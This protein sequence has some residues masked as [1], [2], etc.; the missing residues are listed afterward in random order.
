MLGSSLGVF[1]IRGMG[2]YSSLFAVKACSGLACHAAKERIAT[3]FQAGGFGEWIR[4]MP[5]DCCYQPTKKVFQEELCDVSWFLL[6]G[7]FGLYYKAL[8]FIC[9]TLFCF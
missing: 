5:A 6:V 3:S 7:W 2:L 1:S 4:L 8:W 9:G